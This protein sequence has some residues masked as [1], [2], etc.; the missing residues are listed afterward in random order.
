MLIAAKAV[1]ILF[2]ICPSSTRIKRKD[3]MKF[4][5]LAFVRVQIMAEMY[6]YILAFKVKNYIKDSVCF[7]Y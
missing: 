3:R 4:A 2:H 1:F 5:G 6:F 7:K